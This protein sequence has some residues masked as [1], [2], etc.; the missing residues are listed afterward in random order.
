MIPVKRLTFEI[1]CALWG[2]EFVTNFY[3]PVPSDMAFF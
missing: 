3:Y 2:E 1:L